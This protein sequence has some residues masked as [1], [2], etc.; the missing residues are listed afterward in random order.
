MKKS[1]ARKMTLNRETLRNLQEVDDFQ[2]RYIA[3]GI[4]C[5]KDETTCPTLPQN[6]CLC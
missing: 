6:S 4:R 1:I 5:T 3:G 2:T